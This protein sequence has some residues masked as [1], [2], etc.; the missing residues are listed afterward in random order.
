MVC[1]NHKSFFVLKRLVS[2]IGI[3]C[4]KQAMS[5]K[6]PSILFKKSVFFIGTSVFLLHFFLIALHCLP[7]EYLSERWNSYAHYY[8]YPV[9]HQGW[10]LFAPEPQRKY[11]RMELRYASE[12]AWSEWQHPEQWSE[13][14]HFTWR[15]GP[16]SKVYHVNQGAA[17]HLWQE[18]D[19]FEKQS[20]MAGDYFPYSMGYGVAAHYAQ[21]YAYHCLENR[22]IDSLQVVLIILDPKENGKEQRLEYPTFIPE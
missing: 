7:D 12:G 21:E 19:R 16:W 4:D 3:H 9:F 5:H 14:A 8:S 6:E 13:D 2:K 1:I 11:K 22:P 15:L 18:Q 10:G 17:F 20:K